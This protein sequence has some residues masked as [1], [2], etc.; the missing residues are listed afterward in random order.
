MTR[1]LSP[2]V[3]L[4]AMLLTLTLTA[5][6]Q[7][8]SP[9]SPVALSDAGSPS[10]EAKAD[11][12]RPRAADPKV[13]VVNGCLSCHLE[14]MLAQQRLTQAQWKKV[15]DKMVKWGALV[16]PSEVEPL[17]AYLANIYGLD[18]G[19]FEPSTLE[20]S[21]AAEEIAKLPE[22]GPPGSADRGREIYATMCGD[23]HGPTARGL[24]GVALADKPIIDRPSDFMKVL[25][26]G[27]G[28]MPPTPLSATE[29]ADVRAHLRS[30]RN[31]PH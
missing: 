29:A 7:E 18:A 14:D 6:P 3:M 16:E 27:R 23:C 10:V 19:P 9:V 12:G 28:K 17:A 31:P 22:S 25:D 15:V 2:V 26:Q 20:A 13:L 5:C 30:L 1:W 11:A 21:R 24:V 4:V 8:R